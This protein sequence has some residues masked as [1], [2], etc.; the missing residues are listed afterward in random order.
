MKN[1]SNKLL[2]SNLFEIILVLFCILFIIIIIYRYQL[3]KDEAN[4]ITTINDVKIIEYKNSIKGS[5]KSSK[6]KF[7]ILIKIIK[8]NII[9]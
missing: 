9:K 5:I 4:D 7:L 2:I 8:I 1:N 6:N 3:L